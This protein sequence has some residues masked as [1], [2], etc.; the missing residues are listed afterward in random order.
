MKRQLTFIILFS[1]TA[2]AGYGQG[3][4]YSLQYT[5]TLAAGLSYES[6]KA[7]EDRISQFS[8]PISYLYPRGERMLFYAMT[9]PAFNKFDTGIDYSLDGLSDIKFGGHVLSAN[10]R[11]LFTFGLN[12]PTGKHMLTVNEY[13]VA[14]VLS[15]E[16]LNFRVPSLGQG[17]DIQGGVSTGM[18]KGSMTL[19]GG[20]SYLLKGAFKPFDGFDSA[21]NPG[22][23]VTFT[24]GMN[25]GWLYADL[26]YSIYLDDTWGGERVFR[27]GQRLLLQL[28]G[29]FQKDPWDLVVLVRERMKGRNMTGS[30][31]VYETEKKNSNMNQ[32]EIQGAAYRGEAASFRW[33]GILDIKLYSNNDYG[34]GGATLFGP[35]IGGQRRLSNGIVL[36][37]DIR[38]Y[39]GTIQT[40]KG[41]VDASGIKLYGVFQWML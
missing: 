8:I 20:V 17:F 18:E 15:M 11:W 6:W 23:E 36:D 33:K 2:C 1:L 22:D 29:V 27:S 28:L 9:S 12:L 21:Y 25:R 10:E 40:L 24:L 4:K 37:L 13:P 41:R 26:L 31:S 19:G 35:G 39:L 3:G 32:F 5:R 30:G 7:G 16:A 38:Y 14:S 34:S